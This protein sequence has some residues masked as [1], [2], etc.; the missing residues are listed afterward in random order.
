MT[1]KFSVD[2][3][4]EEQKDG[5]TVERLDGEG[6]SAPDGNEAS[7]RIFIVLVEVCEGREHDQVDDVS[8]TFGRSTLDE[9][10]L[11]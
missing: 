3:M 10:H 7:P 8:L 6:M 2:A 5:R 11:R 1:C 4:S 9:E